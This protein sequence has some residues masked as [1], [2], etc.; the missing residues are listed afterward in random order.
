M[1]KCGVSSKQ[2]AV[3]F[4]CF[5]DLR[6]DETLLS[7]GAGSCSRKPMLVILCSVDHV[8]QVPKGCLFELR[9]GVVQW[10]SGH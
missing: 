9:N 8:R 3:Q 5:V 4:V 1:H 2:I 6:R 10:G 7:L